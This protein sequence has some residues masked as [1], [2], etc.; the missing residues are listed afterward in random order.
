MGFWKLTNDTGEGT[1]SLIIAY[2][3]ALRLELT[4]TIQCDFVRDI[5]RNPVELGKL[6][7]VDRSETLD[8]LSLPHYNASQRRA[9]DTNG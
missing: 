7:T 5:L 6:S 4:D 8:T 2:P 3:Q 9:N 1:V